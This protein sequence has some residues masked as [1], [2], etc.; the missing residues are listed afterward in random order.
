M[1]RGDEDWN[2]ERLRGRVG[3]EPKRDLSEKGEENRVDDY[4]CSERRR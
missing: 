1:M 3:L 2:R 4:G